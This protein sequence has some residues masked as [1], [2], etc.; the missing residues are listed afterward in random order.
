M[1]TQPS[2][3]RPRLRDIVRG[4]AEDFQ[5]TWDTTEASDG[6]DPLPPGVY[7]CLITDG[8]LFTS[9]TN[10]TPGFKVEFQVIA[11]PHAGRK[12]WHD[13][14]LTGKAMAMA[15]G[16]LAKLGI[17]RADQLEHSLPPGLTADVTVVRRTDDGGTTFNRVKTFKVNDADVP[18]V[19][20]RP[21]DLDVERGEG[22]GGP[23][24]AA[25]PASTPRPAAREPG[26]DDD[27][28]DGDD[29]DAQGFDWKRG[30]FRHTSSAPLL[31]AARNG[32][33][34]T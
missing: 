10:Q 1:T 33:A 34:T 22:D 26:E 5:R 13:I 9:R 25:D 30:E 14:W 18:A 15:K 20:Y 32:R 17:V 19:A 12:V 2:D 6:F 29:T 27:L 21:N 7:R 4:A 31:D 16:E 23:L 28:D 11:G 3:K 24:D 8:R